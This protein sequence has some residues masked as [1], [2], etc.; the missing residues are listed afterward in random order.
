MLNA[1]MEEIAL[2]RTRLRGELSE[3]AYPRL[4]AESLLRIGSQLQWLHTLPKDMLSGT[5]LEEIGRLVER[6]LPAFLAAYRDARQAGVIRADADLEQG[7]KHVEE[8]VFSLV[9]K[10]R[11]YAGDT[12]ITFCRY[13]EQRYPLDLTQSATSHW[14]S[15][16][17]ALRQRGLEGECRLPEAVFYS[18]VPP[19][20]LP[21][22]LMFHGK[23]ILK[24]WLN[25][26]LVMASALAF[27]LVLAALG[28]KTIAHSNAD[29]GGS[30]VDVNVEVESISRDWANFGRKEAYQ[31]V[32]V[33]AIHGT[34]T[35]RSK[36]A[37]NSLGLDFDYFDC[38]I[39]Q[40]Q[41]KCRRIAS[42]EYYPTSEIQIPEGVTSAF[43]HQETIPIPQVTGRLAVKV[44]LLPM[45]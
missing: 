14:P 13:L 24:I 17:E 27:G 40:I 41:Y 26:K 35:N 39:D 10:S 44:R 19:P 38:P 32:A 33:L 31:Q 11:K 2:S 42:S 45:R 36:E 30:L 6:R 8:E 7:L 21:G 18:L 4:I 23:N 9:E 20:L 28:G 22:K 5:D 43:R 16:T 1:T 12:L 37:I 15:D 25:R 29:T 34:A 3:W